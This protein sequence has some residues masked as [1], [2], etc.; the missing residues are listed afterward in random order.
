MSEKYNGWANHSTW[1]VALWLQNDGLLYKRAESFI[2]NPKYKKNKSPYKSFILENQMQEQKTPD[3][4]KLYSGSLD[5]KALNE[6]MREL[7]HV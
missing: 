1:N 2:N 3:G 5:Y 7:I 6:M 4:V